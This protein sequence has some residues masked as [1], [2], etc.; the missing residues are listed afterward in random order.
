MKKFKFLLCAL[1]AVLACATFSSCGD[2]DD[3]EPGNGSQNLVGI[4][5]SQ[6][7]IEDGYTTIFAVKLNSDGTGEDGEWDMDSR[8]FDGEG[9]LWRW[10]VDGSQIEITEPDG[11]SRWES[12]TLSADGNSCSIGGDVMVRVR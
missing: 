8:T 6:E 2:D 9:Y 3:D 7:D 11:D 12:F 5:G 1:F 10:R 4:W